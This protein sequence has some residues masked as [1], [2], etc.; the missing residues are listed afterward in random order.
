MSPEVK[1]RGISG[2]T[3]SALCP[4]SI[5]KQRIGQSAASQ[6][7]KISNICYVANLHSHLFRFLRY[8]YIMLLVFAKLDIRRFEGLHFK[9][10]NF[11]GL[12]NF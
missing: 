10:A 6:S 9:D 1:N 3:K 11:I 2:P 7:H 5:L 4:P 8:S 12:F